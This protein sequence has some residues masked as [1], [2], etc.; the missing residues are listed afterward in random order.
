MSRQSRYRGIKKNGVKGIVFP[1]FM[2]QNS[3]PRRH[4]QWVPHQGTK[5]RL[6]GLRHLCKP[7]LE[8]DLDDVWAVVTRLRAAVAHEP[9]PEYAELHLIAAALKIVE[10]SQDVTWPQAAT[11][12]LDK[13]E[14]ME[15][16]ATTDAEVPA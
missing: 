4:R 9:E 13:F 6:R 3:S 10:E 2:N 15:Q 7:I 14:Q 1:S 16:P 11:Y 5:Q 8:S 12:L